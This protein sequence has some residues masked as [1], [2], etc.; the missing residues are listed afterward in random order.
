MP[1]QCG[2]AVSVYG[3]GACQCGGGACQCGGAVWRQTKR[4]ELPRAAGALRALPC[5][6]GAQAA[7]MQCTG[8]AQTVHGAVRVPRLYHDLLDQPE[9]DVGRERALVRL[10]EDDSLVWR[11]ERRCGEGLRIR[12]AMDSLAGVRASASHLALSGTAAPPACGA[13]HSQRCRPRTQ[14]VASCGAPTVALS[15]GCARRVALEQR[16][17]HRL[18]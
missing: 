6:G 3:G 15:T 9:E 17:G 2:R 16:V 14:G 1:C 18:A 11:R 13:T 8:S 7:R 4:P 12:R 5:A 10:V